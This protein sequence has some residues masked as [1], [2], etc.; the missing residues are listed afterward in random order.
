MGVCG[1]FRAARRPSYDPAPRGTSSVYPQENARQDAH[2]PCS[3]PPVTSTAPAPSRRLRAAYGRAGACIPAADGAACDSECRLR[4]AGLLHGGQGSCR[5][6]HGMPRRPQQALGGQAPPARQR[7]DDEGPDSPRGTA[8][9]AAR[10]SRTSSW[11]LSV[12]CQLLP[13]EALLLAV[14]PARA[15][16]P[17]GALG[18]PF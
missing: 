15:P 9:C 14:R 8:P 12:A 11:A 10:S 3:S 1:F 4:A 17:F 16:E 5:Q 18:R 2:A 13:S 6:I 7:R